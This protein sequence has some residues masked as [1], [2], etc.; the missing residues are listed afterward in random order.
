MMRRLAQ[1]LIASLA[2]GLAGASAT[3]Q[4]P[5]LKCDVGPVT[6]TYG[7]TPWLVYSCGDGRSVVFVAGPGNP[8]APFYFIMHP[9][10]Q[11][12]RLEGEG[13]GSKTITDAAYADLSTLTERDIAALIEQTKHP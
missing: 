7:K 3:A 4:T 2:M 13:T 11:G 12:Y 5:Q 8:G 9:D 6:K 1:I 10:A